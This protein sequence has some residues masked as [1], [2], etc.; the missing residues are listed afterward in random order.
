MVHIAD[1]KNTRRL[2]FARHGYLPST[3]R[4]LDRANRR[5]GFQKVEHPATHSLICSFTIIHRASYAL[6]GVFAGRTERQLERKEDRDGFF[7]RTCV[8]VNDLKLYHFSAIRLTRSNILIVAFSYGF[9]LTFYNIRFQARFP[10][11]FFLFLFHFFLNYNELKCYRRYFV[12][13]V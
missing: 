13:V 3:R 5:T 12:I 9:V 6:A 7:P 8:P 11:Y 10:Q 2:V 1:P 4:K